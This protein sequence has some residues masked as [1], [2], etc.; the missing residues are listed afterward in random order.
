MLESSVRDSL[1]EEMAREG[2]RGER[3]S[4][5]DQEQTQH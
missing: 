2:R 4:K 5:C 1:L 3:C